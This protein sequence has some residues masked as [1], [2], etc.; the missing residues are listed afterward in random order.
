MSSCPQRHP[1]TA[2]PHVAAFVATGI[3][4]SVRKRM[5]QTPVMIGPQGQVEP[6]AKSAEEAAR[7]G[8]GFRSLI[9]R[10]SSLSKTPFF[11]L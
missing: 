5:R 7:K 11:V 9:T 4:V 1:P 3:D 2:C 10:G 8:R 6:S